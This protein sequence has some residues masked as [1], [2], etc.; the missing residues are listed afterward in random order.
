M[1]NTLLSKTW[2]YS[3][4]LMAVLLLSLEKRFSFYPAI[5]WNYFKISFRSFLD[6]SFGTD[7]QFEGF[8]SNK[9]IHLLIYFERI[10]FI[11]LSFT[12]KIHLATHCTFWQSIILQS[13]NLL[14]YVLKSPLIKQCKQSLKTVYSLHCAKNLIRTIPNGYPLYNG[15]THWRYPKFWQHFC[16]PPQSLSE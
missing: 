7:I 4:K 14:E 13:S 10:T 8:A 5:L 11:W 3:T 9:I 15:L 16:L 1:I 2:R 6:E 12:L